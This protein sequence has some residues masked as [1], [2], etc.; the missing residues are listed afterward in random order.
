MHK[1]WTDEELYERYDLT[2]KEIS[3]IENSIKEMK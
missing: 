1:E 2:Q 3:Y